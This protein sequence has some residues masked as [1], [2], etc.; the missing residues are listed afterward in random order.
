MRIYISLYAPTARSRIVFRAWDASVARCPAADFVVCRALRRGGCGYPSSTTLCSPSRRHHE[1]TGGERPD[2]NSN[3]LMAAGGPQRQCVQSPETRG[4]C[5]ATAQILAVLKS[6]QKPSSTY[7]ASPTR[8]W[9][10]ACSIRGPA[11]RSED[12]PR[13]TPQHAR[14]SVC[15]SDPSGSSGGSSRQDVLSGSTGG[16]SAATK[17]PVGIAAARLWTARPPRGSPDVR[18]GRQSTPY[19]ADGRPPPGT[20]RRSGQGSGVALGGVAY[21]G[22]LVAR[23]RGMLHGRPAG[24]QPALPPAPRG[25]LPSPARRGSGTT[26]AA[27]LPPRSHTRLAGSP[28]QRLLR[29]QQRRRPM[30]LG[31][32]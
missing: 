3:L 15:C 27:K 26:A 23:W 32:R 10:P 16:P 7:T 2:R 29:R 17:H 13:V 5:A 14:I 28:A 31:R 11:A 18:S 9:S 12:A 22:A 8:R 4:I 25:R 6:W 30:R 20:C 21:S 24:A 1:H 19:T